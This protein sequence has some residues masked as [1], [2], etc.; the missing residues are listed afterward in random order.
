M[1]FAIL[2]VTLDLTIAAWFI[3]RKIKAADAKSEM[4]DHV[5]TVHGRV[6]ASY[7]DGKST[8][9]PSFAGYSVTSKGDI[10]DHFTIERGTIATGF[11][12][13]VTVSPSVNGVCDLWLH[14]LNKDQ[15]DPYWAYHRTKHTGTI[16]YTTDKNGKM[17]FVGFTPD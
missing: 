11:L 14:S 12:L 9:Y 3:T 1:I 2:L 4:M 16:S 6:E 17:Y 10:M 15:T 5:Q 8:A 13:N 7:L